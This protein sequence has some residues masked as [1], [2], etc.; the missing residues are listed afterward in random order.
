MMLALL[1]AEY[2]HRPHVKGD[3]LLSPTLLLLLLLPDLKKV[4]GYPADQASQLLQV[5]KV[6]SAAASPV[7]HARQ[8]NT[9]LTCCNAGTGITFTTEPVITSML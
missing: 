1:K 4:I 7:T 8:R 3:L 9:Q 6:R 2:Q 5:W